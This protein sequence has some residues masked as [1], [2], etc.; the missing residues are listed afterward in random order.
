MEDGNQISLFLQQVINKIRVRY[1]SRRAEDTYLHWIK[2]Y[3][4]S[5]TPNIQTSLKLSIYFLS[6]SHSLMTRQSRALLAEGGGC[7]V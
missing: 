7:Y 2:S 4:N 3:C 6:V 5:W 1:Y